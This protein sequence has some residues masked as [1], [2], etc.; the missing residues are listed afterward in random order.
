MSAASQLYKMK[1]FSPIQM[2]TSPI[3]EVVYQLSLSSMKMKP[4][5]PIQMHTSPIF[6]V[7]Y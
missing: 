2:H 3:F 6:E 7:V 4:F 1:L 5:S